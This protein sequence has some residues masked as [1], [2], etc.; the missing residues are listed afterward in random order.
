MPRRL[1]KLMDS[2]W[3]LEE[4]PPL[5]MKGGTAVFY[6]NLTE[7]DQMKEL[8]N[9]C[10]HHVSLINILSAQFLVTKTRSYRLF[11]GYKIS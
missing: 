10:W 7:T 1:G 4:Y 8:Q 5:L 11:Y 6:C 9:A 3:N 2:V